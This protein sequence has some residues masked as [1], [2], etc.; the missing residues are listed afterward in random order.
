MAPPS[1]RAQEPRILYGD[2]NSISFVSAPIR[3]ALGD[4]G[5]DFTLVFSDEEFLNEVRFRR[6]DLVILRSKRRFVEPFEREIIAE[7]E[8]HVAGGGALHFQM[9]DLENAPAELLDVLGIADAIDLR[10]PLSDIEF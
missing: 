6:W 3:G 8:A 7:L 9:A 10:F 4:L 1:A 2:L 5:L